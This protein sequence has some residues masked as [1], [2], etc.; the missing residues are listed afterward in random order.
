MKIFGYEI[1]KHDPNVTTIN[2]NTYEH[3]VNP[4]PYDSRPDLDFRDI[5]GDDEANVKVQ[6]LEYDY[7]Y[8]ISKHS[9]TLRT[10]HNNLNRE[11]FRNGGE[12]QKRFIKKCI[13]CNEE[14]E[15]DIDECTECGSKKLRSPD[16]DQKKQLQLFIKNVNDN[17]QNIIKMSKTVNQDI[18]TTDDGYMHMVCDYIWD[19]SGELVK[20]IPVELVR[21]DPRVI[22]FISDKKG[23]P[24]RNIEGDKILFCLEH[25]K[26]SYKGDTYTHCPICDRRL[27]PAHYRTNDREGYT[28]YSGQEIHHESKYW[29]TMTNGFSPIYAAWFKV[30]TLMGQ[31]RYISTYYNKQRSPKGMLFLN[32]LNQGSFQ[33]AWSWMR[34]QFKKNPHIVPPVCIEN[35]N[36]QKGKLVEFIDFMRSL[37]EM[38][39][40]QQRDEFCRKIGILYG[41]QPMFQA[42]LTQGGGLNSEGLQVTVTNRALEA[43]QEIFNE[44]FYPWVCELLDVTDWEYVLNPS[45]EKD[46]SAEEDLKAKKIMNASQMQIMGFDVKLKN[47]EELEFEYG[48]VGKDVEPEVDLSNPMKPP[49]SNP[50]SQ[51]PNTSANYQGSP[52]GAVKGDTDFQ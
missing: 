41:V 48:P 50:F 17:K 14:F 47:A 9:D 44:G 42:D 4:N 24:G 34:D 22:Q 36:G 2:K 32:V 12:I 45:E 35:P 16:I 38:Q 21:V 1:K 28:Y 51:N 3:L 20:S 6:P 40:T 31:D 18:E 46:N 37:D 15:M 43:G 25:R 13:K 8:Q 10:I 33:K 23:R 52:D 19:K 11:I 7:L 26:K 27:Q 39:F 29:P 5:L 49:K 30:E